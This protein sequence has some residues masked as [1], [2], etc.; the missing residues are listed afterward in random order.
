MAQDQYQQEKL[1]QAQF[2]HSCLQQQLNL[3]YEQ[4]LKENEMNYLTAQEV[5][6]NRMKQV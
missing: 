1:K 3:K 4:L 5:K 6:Y 2:T